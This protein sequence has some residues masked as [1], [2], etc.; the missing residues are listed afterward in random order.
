MEDPVT[1]DPEKK[2]TILVADD[3]VVT[4]EFF[5]VMLS[6]LGFSVIPVR[7]GQA[8]LDVLPQQPVD[9]IILDN[10]LPKR[11]GWEVTSMLRN[12]PAY[13][14]F[15][16]IPIIML[17]ALISVQ[18][19]IEGYELGIDDYITKPFNFSEIFARINAVLR[20]R[21]VEQQVVQRERRLALI[22][23]LKDS[24]VYF[25]RH[26][27]SPV[28]VMEMGAVEVEFD[29]PDEV[30]K[31]T[32]AVRKTSGEILSA[33]RALEEKVRDLE[34][35]EDVLKKRELTLQDLE[36]QY[37]RNRQQIERIFNNEQKTGDSSK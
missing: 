33:L 37:R 15:R 6:K 19:K 3:D 17:S 13:A 18:D 21:S 5:D 9:L 24:L 29:N 22:D 12:D 36:R 8:I 20:H 34:Q 26:I 27:E 32:A 31:F 35:Q 14:Q 10:I 16:N 2:L 28:K 25:S 7:D 30:K 4:V 23:T 11:L 1:Q